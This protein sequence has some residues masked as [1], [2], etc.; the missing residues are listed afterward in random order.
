MAADSFDVVNGLLFDSVPANGPQQIIKSTNKEDETKCS[1][2]ALTELGQTS[3]RIRIFI[4]FEGS[5]VDIE[6]IV[7]TLLLGSS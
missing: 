1:A 5:D 7:F 6:S 3:L 4:C 2:H